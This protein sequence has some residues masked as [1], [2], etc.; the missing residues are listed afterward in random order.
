MIKVPAFLLKRLYV[1]GSLR[2]TNEG[3]EF[4]LKNGLGSGYA[5]GMLPIRIDGEEIPIDDTTFAVDG[6]KVGFREVT[7]E[8]PASLTM[9]REATI[10]VKRTQVARGSAQ[11]LSRLRGLWPRRAELRSDGQPGRRL[12]KYGFPGEMQ[13]GQS[14]LPRVWGSPMHILTRRSPPIGPRGIGKGAEAPYLGE[15]EG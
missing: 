4:R 1:K 15:R 2:N 5:A 13:E 10:A 3:F 6:K 8:Q 7:K 9:N 12:A 14:L 11:G